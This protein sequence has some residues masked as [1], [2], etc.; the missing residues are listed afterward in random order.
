MCVLLLFTPFYFFAVIQKRNSLSTVIVLLLVCIAA[1]YTVKWSTQYYKEN[2]P[3]EMYFKQFNE[4]RGDVTD[5]GL[6][7]YVGH[8]EEYTKAGISRNDA[9]MLGW[10]LYGDKNVFSRQMMK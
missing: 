3:D 9:S 10:F 4:Y 2:I 7:N 8:Q 5:R 1:N 6:I